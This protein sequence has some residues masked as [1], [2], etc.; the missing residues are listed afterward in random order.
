M[1]HQIQD[2]PRCPPSRANLCH[3]G[4]S[5]QLRRALA[6]LACSP[7]SAK[8]TLK[9]QRQWSETE[10]GTSPTHPEASPHL[11]YLYLPEISHRAT[12]TG[13]LKLGL[14]SLSSREADAAS[15]EGGCKDI[16]DVYVQR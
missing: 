14:L 4:S 7:S 10:P 11:R 12:R 16:A 8:A 3:G 13:A 5:L 1:L 15:H 2:Y 9:F 6:S